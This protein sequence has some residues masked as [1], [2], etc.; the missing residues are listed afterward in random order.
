MQNF[1]KKY[2]Y[3][4]YNGINILKVTKGDKMIDN[5]IIV[6]GAGDIATGVIHKLHRCGFNALALEVK[7]PLSIKRKVCFSEAIYDGEV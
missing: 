6:R 1:L 3:I 7:N 5:L 4:L 2:V